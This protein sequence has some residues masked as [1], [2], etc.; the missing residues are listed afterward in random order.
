MKPFILAVSI[1]MLLVLTSGCDCTKSSDNGKRDNETNNGSVSEETTFAIAD[2]FP[3]RDNIRTFYEG[4]GNEFA[5]YDVY[6]EYAT[7]NTVQQRINNGGTEKT[8]VLQRIDGKLVKRFSQAEI[9]YRQNFLEKTDQSEILL[10]EPLVTGTT[11]TLK[12]NR[13]RTITSVSAE[14][15]TPSGN[16]QAL[17][18]TTENPNDPS[19]QTVDY[20]AK[21]VGLVK[22]VFRYGENQTDTISSSLRE[23][24]ENAVMTQ[25]VNFYY[26]SGDDDTI[27]YQSKAVNFHTNDI[28]RKVLADA[29]KENAPATV[30]SPNTRINS[31]YLN[32]DGM[33]YL[34]LSTDFI[35]EMNAGAGYES[36]MLQCLANTFGHY[37][38]AQ[39]IILTIDNAPYASGHILLEK[40]EFLEVTPEDA[41]PMMR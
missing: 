24:Q 31:L 26:P 25:T 7:K 22:T 32:D 41:I 23:I 1:V 13:V 3:I 28:T 33:V 29:Y 30:L 20:Y 8:E 15:A 27:F 12:D 18:V 39:K 34:D 38:N 14:I 17:E 5:T 6:N 10:L 35:T 11:W 9:Y 36:R 16:Y 37:Y 2:Y 19:T 4:Q 21:D 40:G